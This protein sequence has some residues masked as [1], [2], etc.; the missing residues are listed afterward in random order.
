[1]SIPLFRIY[2]DEED[3]EIV[4][5]VIE[6][7]KNWA[8]G[9]YN[10]T[11]EKMLANY[12]ERNYAISF[13]S[14][15]S[16]LFS[17]LLAYG[18]KN[19]DEVI[20]PSFTFISTANSVLM[21]GGKP[22]FAD[23]ELEC[24]GLEPEDVVEKI[25]PKTKTIIPVH[26]AGC[27][28]KIKE[29]K[30][31]AEDYNLLLL[32][33]AAES[34]GARINDKKVGSF[35]DSAMLS[36]CQNKIITTGEGGAIVTDSE[37]IYE[38]LKLIRSHGRLEKT[39]YFTSND[40]FSYIQLGYNFRLSNILAALGVSQLKKVDLIIKKRQEKAKYYNNLLDDISFIEPLKPPRS[41]FH[42][43]QLYSIFVK[44]GKRQIV[45]DTLKEH[46]IASKI[47]FD[48]VHLSPFYKKLF[49][50]KSPVLQN[51]ERVSEE[52]LSLPFHP[53]I[54]EEEMLLIKGV[55]DKI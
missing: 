21:A 14:G 6:S 19:G 25:T 40:G 41:Y 24:L 31:I 22:V 9:E 48:P 49:G 50:T 7:G 13:N 20:V 45:I 51:T 46:K 26:Y 15:T 53:E 2:H 16:A 27:P 18:I 44:E 54:K 34:F 28:C 3:S 17:L 43:Y 47:Y 36:F 8:I 33:D 1:M 37:E 39:N 5:N 23:I 52:I 12:F 42:V 55:L 4:K 10:D 35:G 32:E 29:L 38:K 30:E 11:F